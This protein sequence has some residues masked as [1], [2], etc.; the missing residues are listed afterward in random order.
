MVA[1]LSGPIIFLLGAG[2]SV[3]LGMP[4]TL[5]L[6]K[7]LCDQTSIGKLA[8]E[9]HGS[10][11]YRFRL[12]EDDVNVESFLE[13]LY[14]LKLLVWLA[15]RSNVPTLLPRFTSVDS[16]VSA[17]AGEKLDRLEARVFALVEETCGDC[18]GA[19]A[20]A[21][22][23]KLLTSVSARQPR[24]AIF[25]LNYDWT[26]ERLAIAR[27]K[28]Y[29]LCDGFELLGGTWDPR[30][31]SAAPL[32][33]KI[34]ISLFKLHGSTT[35]VGEGPVKSMAK[36]DTGGAGFVTIPP[37]HAYEISMG[38]EYWRQPQPDDATLPF[39]TAEPFKALQRMFR[40]AL[41]SAD[42]LVVIGYAFHDRHINRQIEE[43]LAANK[44]LQVLVVDPG[45]RHGQA[46]FEWL[47]YALFEADW[48]RFHWLQRRFESGT[49][50]EVVK[51]IGIVNAT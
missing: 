3:P 47:K 5:D 17:A 18:D 49:A 35:W 23:R 8:A 34:N 15:R 9:V 26:F 28:R 36:F 24:V 13:H 20:D 39:L 14:E 38:D 16:D 40:K 50:S 27:P 29:E 48:S 45:T 42:T 30:R 2:A 32:P 1:Q 4:T 43:A 41:R 44:R 22:W 46:P 21:L 33:G 37:G 6:R 7:R 51:A 19:A 31:F 11:A 12:S 10:A 25:T